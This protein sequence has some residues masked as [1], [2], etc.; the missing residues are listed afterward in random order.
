M[1]EIVQ[2]LAAL[3]NWCRS[4]VLCLDNTEWNV[5]GK[6]FMNQCLM[7]PYALKSVLMAFYYIIL[8]YYYH[9]RNTK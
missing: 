7:E 9:A 2:L 6:K 3:N 4:D 8:I 5:N 1:E